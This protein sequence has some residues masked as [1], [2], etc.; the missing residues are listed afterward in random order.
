MGENGHVTPLSVLPTLQK[1]LDRGH[2]AYRIEVM[3]G[4]EHGYTMP[5]MPA[6]NPE[7]AERAWAGTL[8]LLH[9]RLPAARG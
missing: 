6:Y 4:A 9:R 2:V 7:A 3:P 8:E 1:E 5:S